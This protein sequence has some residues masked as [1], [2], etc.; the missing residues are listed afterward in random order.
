MYDVF[1]ITINRKYRGAVHK[2]CN[3]KLV[4]SKNL[5]ILFHNLE[6]YDGHIIFKELNNI[7]NINIE[8][9]PKSTGKYMSIIINRD[10][11]FLN[12][13]QFLNKSLDALASNLED[14]DRKYLSF[15]FKSIDLE[16]LKKKDPYPYE[17]VTNIKKFDYPKL[18]P[19]NAY[20]SRLNKNKRNKS[21]PISNEEYNRILDVW[22]ILKFKRFKDYHNLYL[23]KDVILLAD[24]FEKFI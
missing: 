19:K 10:M 22:N 14:I 20:N 6:G 8:V 18:P 16:L 24:V 2:K 23:K 17:W 15:E 7:N 5:P 3:L 1:Y 11:I 13:M 4:I 21:S 12:S 9:I